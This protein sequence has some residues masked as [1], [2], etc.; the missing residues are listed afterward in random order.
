MVFF[1]KTV[2]FF[3][4]FENLA[5]SITLVSSLLPK[6]KVGSPS[7]SNYAKIARKYENKADSLCHEIQRD[8]NLTF[9][10]PIDR[11]DIYNLAIKLDNIVDLIENLI[12]NLAA[13]S[14]KTEE[15]EFKPFIKLVIHIT[16]NLV[17]LISKLKYRERKIDEM[18]SFMVKI[19]KLENQGDELIRK[20]YHSLFSNHG[21]PIEIIKWKDLYTNMES[22][23][24]ECEKV[25]SLVDEVI[26]KNF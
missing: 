20:A 25:A 14:I 22:I 9:I 7:L 12:S 8:V 1:P 17:M 3:L 24:D 19:N 10:T 23:L 13:F 11:E 26:I 16:D 21:D 18:R 5:S 15:K 4:R 2:D 6:V